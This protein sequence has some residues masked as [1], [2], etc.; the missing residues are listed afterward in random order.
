M[1]QNMNDLQT[2]AFES[3]AYNPIAN[4][5]DGKEKLK[6]VEIQ[7]KGGYR[8]Q[9]SVKAAPRPN[10]L[11]NAEPNDTVQDGLQQRNG[12][13]AGKGYGLC[14][15]RFWFYLGNEITTCRDQ[16]EDKF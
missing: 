11:Q 16:A 9:D 12:G 13:A 6:E 1:I 3:F 15:I 7:K 5:N 14:L 4:R 10:K 8:E 2:V